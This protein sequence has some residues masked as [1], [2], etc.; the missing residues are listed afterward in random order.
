MAP[1]ILGKGIRKSSIWKLNRLVQNRKKGRA[2]RVFCLFV[3]VGCFFFS[4]PM[5]LFSL[6]RKPSWKTVISIVPEIF[7]MT[8]CLFED[9]HKTW[10]TLW[11]FI[12][13]VSLDA[14]LYLFQLKNKKI[15]GNKKI[16]FF[17]GIYSSFF[18]RCKILLE[19]QVLPFDHSSSFFSRSSFLDQKNNHT[20]F[21]SNRYYLLMEHNTP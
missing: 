18:Q 4:K 20:G 1:Y 14:F 8:E 17:L 13:H 10:T 15:Y 9:R 21:L 12:A 19:M 6:W 7:I 2:F 3:F 16:P 5:R 11:K